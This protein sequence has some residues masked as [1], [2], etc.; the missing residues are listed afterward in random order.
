MADIKK[1]TEEKKTV[2]AAAAE[3]KKEEPAK[4]AAKPATNPAANKPAAKKT[5]AKPAAKKTAAKPAAKKG[6][7]FILQ[8]G[9]AEYDIDSIKKRVD[10]A[11]KN[12]GKK[13]IKSVDIYVKPEDRAAY[14]VIN[15][16]D[17]SKID[18]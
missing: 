14:Y 6:N 17:S 7:S 8:Y 18:L 11:V 1:T 9:G 4:T 15:G 5:A 16:K 2:P 10:E 13:N 3:V 12:S